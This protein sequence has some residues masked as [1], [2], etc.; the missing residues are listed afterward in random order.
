VDDELHFAVR[1][2]LAVSGGR[3][4]ALSTPND[5]RGWFHRE[6]FNGES[7]QT[8]KISAADCPRIP[9][10]FLA[11]ERRTLTAARYASEYE[12]EFTDAIDSV[13]SH[14]DVSAALDPSLTPLYPGGW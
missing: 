11:E 10:S 4:L 3:L 7:W 12:C 13:F 14:A 6:W 5:Q 8:T 2:M 1:P 9:D